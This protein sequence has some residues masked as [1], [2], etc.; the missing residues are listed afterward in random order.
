MTEAMK[1]VVRQIL[2]ISRRKKSYA[3]VSQQLRPGPECQD[4]SVHATTLLFLPEVSKVV[5]SEQADSCDLSAG[6]GSA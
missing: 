2:G 5:Q 4:R 6:L 1:A 3:T